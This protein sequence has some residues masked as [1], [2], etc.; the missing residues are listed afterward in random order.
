MKNT[1]PNDEQEELAEQEQHLL[2]QIEAILA[3]QDE[4][5]A[6]DAFGEFIHWLAR[7]QPPT[8]EAFQQRLRA[9]L[10]AE[11]TKKGEKKKMAML[12][13]QSS[14]KKFFTWRQAFAALLLGAAC[15]V[16]AVW[17]YPPGRAWARAILAQ[18]GP[19]TITDNPTLPE[20]MLTRTPTPL[21]TEIPSTP[22]PDD[23]KTNPPGI[24]MPEANVAD[25]ATASQMAG[26][27]VLAPHYIPTGYE[28]LRIQLL[29][30]RDGTFYEVSTEYD[31]PHERDGYFLL[32]QIYA[33]SSEG[34]VPAFEWPVGD[35]PVVE[36]TVRGQPGVWV[37]QSNQGQTYNEAGE[38]VL[39]QW[40][41]LLWQEDDFLFWFFSKNLS[42]DETLKI[43]E[44][45][46]PATE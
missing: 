6:S 3:G 16:M 25:A 24:G 31:N 18:S 1:Y 44:S 7:A 17:L 29:Q 38:P 15:L 4:P 14:T 26:F 20:Q 5:P 42:Q 43:A 40:N 12:R 32:R 46:L 39:S 45:L 8:H 27:A 9:E 22:S 10:M 28:L 30:S 41:M 21:P 23:L 19:V 33:P 35:A 13:N 34:D 36:L 11:T 2:Q 37:E